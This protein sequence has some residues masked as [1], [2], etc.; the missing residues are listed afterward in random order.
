VIAAR[1]EIKA[2]LTLNDDLRPRIAIWFKQYRIHIGMRLYPCR[3]C[4]PGLGSADFAAIGAD[5]AI[6]GHI[7]RFERGDPRTG[8]P[9]Q[10][11]QARHQGAFTG[12]RSGALHHQGPFG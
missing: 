11:A 8:T 7:L 12:I 9:G 10:T 6:Q 2:R 1:I 3:K 5:R 4:L